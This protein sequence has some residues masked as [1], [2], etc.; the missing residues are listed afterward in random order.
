MSK[1]SP[2]IFEDSINAPTDL[3]ILVSRGFNEREACEAL[4]QA[5][6][7]IHQAHQ[8]LSGK[9]VDN[10]WLNEIPGEWEDN[11]TI[12]MTTPGSLRA[13]WKSPYYVRVGSFKRVQS[14]DTDKEGILYINTVIT[15]DGRQ[16]TVEKR[17]TEYYSLW[18]SLPVGITRNFENKFPKLSVFQ[19]NSSSSD[20][21]CEERRLRLE[22]WLRELCFDEKC[23]TNPKVLKAMDK[24]LCADEHG[25]DVD[26][27]TSASDS[28]VATKLLEQSKSYLHDWVV[29]PQTS[30]ENLPVSLDVITSS[31]PCKIDLDLVLGS[32]G[33][34]SLTGKD[35]T[36]D[37]LSKDLSRD[38]IVIQGRRIMGSN[39]DLGFIL[40]QAISTANNVLAERNSKTFPQALVSALCKRSLML[41]SRTESAYA[42]H[43]ALQLLLTPDTLTELIVVPEAQL[44]KP[45]L[46]Q[47]RVETPV[48][49]SQKESAE[50]KPRKSLSSV[51]SISASP[52]TPGG[53]STQS[54]RRQSIGSTQLNSSPSTTANAPVERDLI[55]D[56]QASTVF[57]LVD[58]ETMEKTH[59]QVKITFC[60]SIKLSHLACN[61]NLTHEPNRQS[62]NP[63]DSP[64]AQPTNTNPFDECDDNCEMGNQPQ[65]SEPPAATSAASAPSTNFDDEIAQYYTDSSAYLVFERETT[66]TKRDWENK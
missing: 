13:L 29:I 1:S 28:S 51:S 21:K 32:R 12:S 24:F 6:G 59:L 46:M 25:D 44:A 57:R 2:L 37:Q 20:S 50:A 34:H 3:E 14:T 48:D 35:I 4:S 62:T 49:N 15:R 22:E 23:M 19:Y 17:F 10:S 66:S 40:T 36:D 63:F 8:I 42:S 65:S 43:A 9:Q 45:L 5:R 52:G 56:I 16:W 18:M 58:A 30:I 39:T 38:R 53:D 64:V 54:S 27:I 55:C 7:D 41:V 33:A 26:N 60:K 61:T 31:L 11:A 47:F